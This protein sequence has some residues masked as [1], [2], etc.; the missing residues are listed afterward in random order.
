MKNLKEF[1]TESIIDH[2]GLK[3]MKLRDDF[4]DNDIRK[5]LK[6]HDSLMRVRLEDFITYL[7]DEDDKLNKIYK[8][9]N[10]HNLSSAIKEIARTKFGKHGVSKNPFDDDEINELCELFNE[11]YKLKFN[12]D[13][14]K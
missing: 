3:L 9:N 2:F 11:V 4:W 10:I 7:L 12:T 14:C 13:I 6:N 1:L 8:T 5:L